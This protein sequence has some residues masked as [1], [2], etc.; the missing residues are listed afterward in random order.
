MIADSYP[1]QAIL[2]SNID[3]KL[4][5]DQYLRVYVLEWKILAFTR[6]ECDFRRQRIAFPHVT[7]SNHAKR[8][9]A[10]LVILFLQ[11]IH[12]WDDVQVGTLLVAPVFTTVRPNHAYSLS[13]MISF[14]VIGNVTVDVAGGIIET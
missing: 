5:T 12:V 4:R 11:V 3:R 9:N 1:R 10:Y 6:D 13:I 14:E 7:R 8:A 2:L